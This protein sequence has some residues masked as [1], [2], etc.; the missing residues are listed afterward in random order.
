MR[1]KQSKN[2]YNR[3]FRVKSSLYYHYQKMMRQYLCYS[4]LTV[5]LIVFVSPSL[6]CTIIV[7]RTISDN[8]PERFDDLPIVE[9]RPGHRVSVEC[10]SS[11]TNELREGDVN[12]GSSQKSFIVRGEET[13]RNV[14]Y[15]CSCT[16]TVG[17][18][19]TVQTIIQTIIP[20]SEST[21]YLLQHYLC[22]KTCSSTHTPN[23]RHMIQS[24]SQNEMYRSSNDFN[25]VTLLEQLNSFYV[26][27]F[28]YRAEDN[29]EC[30]NLE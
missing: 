8:S 16:N 18:R 30:H 28:I 9:V 19:S 7:R 23:T 10:S 26:L 17:T 4:C 11:G 20:P 6:A 27:R 14:T 24:N 22:S 12:T 29:P 3:Q 21:Q 2:V 13:D 25:A 5:F 15:T 1:A